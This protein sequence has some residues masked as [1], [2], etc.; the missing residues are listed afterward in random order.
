[1]HVLRNDEMLEESENKI[2]A[3]TASAIT[4]HELL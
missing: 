1:M 3:I 4:I 2:N